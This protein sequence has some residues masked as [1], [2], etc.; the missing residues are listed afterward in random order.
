METQN[1]I[2]EMEKLGL[3][4]VELFSLKP[5]KTKR[6]NTAWGTKTLLGLGRTIFRIT[7]EIK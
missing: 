3:K 6:Y 5:D 7:N 4:I 1:E 2:K